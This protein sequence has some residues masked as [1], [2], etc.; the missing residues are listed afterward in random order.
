MR[1]VIIFSLGLVIINFTGCSTKEINT[2]TQV[3]KLEKKS[4]KVVKKNSPKIEKKRIVKDYTTVINENIKR[5][6]NQKKAR[7]DFEKIQKRLLAKMELARKN[8]T[9]TD[10]R[11]KY[12]KSKDQI[13]K[14]LNAAQKNLQSVIKK[15]E[16]VN[17]T[18]NKNNLH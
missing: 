4:T 18:E 5:D 2:K 7:A 9:E 11:E 3:K 10:D 17:Y 6:K 1:N 12:I 14:E 8:F 16:I 15:N 13:T